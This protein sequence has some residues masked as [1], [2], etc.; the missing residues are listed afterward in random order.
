MRS[1]LGDVLFG[2]GETEMG[3]L[4]PLRENTAADQEASR[5]LPCCPVSGHALRCESR[6]VPTRNLRSDL[7]SELLDLVGPCSEHH[8]PS[9]AHQLPG[10]A[11]CTVD[12]LREHGR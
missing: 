2:R 1:Y 4:R 9:G 7:L 6:A 8:L 12:R 5:E 3:R 10:V 11:G